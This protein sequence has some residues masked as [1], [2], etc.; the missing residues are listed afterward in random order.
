MTL[1]KIKKLLK[2]LSRRPLTD[3]HT[4]LKHFYGE[5]NFNYN[6]YLTLRKQGTNF[7]QTFYPTK[8]RGRIV[9]FFFFNFFHPEVLKHINTNVS[10]NNT[11]LYF[12]YNKN[13]ILS[14]RHVS[15][16]IRSSSGPLR[17]QI[18]ELSIF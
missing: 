12:I 13:S 18:Q 15:T 9:S 7:L 16:F 3:H 6:S 5:L 8:H 10:V 1:Q 4:S 2:I 11:T 14:G 17:K